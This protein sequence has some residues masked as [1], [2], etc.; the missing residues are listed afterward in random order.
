M[1]P[2]HPGSQNHFYTGDSQKSLSPAHSVF[3]QETKPHLS[4]FFRVFPLN[5]TPNLGIWGST[6]IYQTPGLSP[7]MLFALSLFPVLREE[8]FSLPV[9]KDKG[10]GIT[11][12]SSCHTPSQQS[13]ERILL[14]P[15]SICTQR[16]TTVSIYRWP[17]HQNP[18]SHPNSSRRLLIGPFASFLALYKLF[19]V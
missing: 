5:V 6:K 15:S 16:V 4:N 19:S 13:Q 1:T 8:N 2:E 10:P 17:L 12:I 11:T 18:I 3:A 14:A 9:A 7:Y